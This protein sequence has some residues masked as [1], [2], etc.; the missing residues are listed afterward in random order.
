MYVK[1]KLELTWV[2]KND[3]LKIE[4]RILLVDKEKSYG[5]KNSGNMLIHGDNLLGLRALE[6]DYTN[7]IKCVYIDPPY[8]TGNAFEH[9]DDNLEHSIWLNL[10]NER[11]KI[12]Y[13]LLKNDGG[14]LI[15]Q[16]DVQEI[17]YCKILLDEI[18]G[19]NQFVA[20]ITYE[21]SGVGGLGQSGAIINTGEYILIYQKGARRVNEVKSYMPIELKQMKRYNKMIIDFGTKELVREFSSKSNG[22]TVK[23]FK[24]NNFKIDTFSFKDKKDE[25]L[26]RKEYG[27]CYD[28]LFRSFL[29]QKENAFQ[30]DIIKD[31]DKSCLY[32]VEYIPSRGKYEGQLTNLYYINKELIGWLKDTAYL[33]NGEVVKESKLTNIWSN[34][35]IP[36]ADLPNE[37]HVTFPRNKKP[38][39]LIKR[40]LDMFT[41]ENDLVLDSFL[42]SGTTAAVAHK[43]KRRWIGIEMGNHIYTH[44]IPRLKRIIDGEDKTGITKTMNWTGGGGYDFYELSPS[45]I[46]KDKFEESIINRKYD[47]NMLSEAIALQEGYDYNPSK[48]FFWKQAK[49]NENSFLYVTLDFIDQVLLEKIYNQMAE[50]EYLIVYCTNYDKKIENKFKR[51]KIKKIPESLLL[52]CE[53]GIENYNLNIKEEFVGEEYEEC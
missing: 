48:K 44:C 45:L 5:E 47:L 38:E 39:Q 17:H 53:Y 35:E 19:R 13:K 20:Q 28:K 16:L 46:E 14:T 18:F 30:H 21:R 37:G 31:M 41:K 3:N 34:A 15:V 49:G 32:S 50:N 8:N 10:M 33:E 12:L 29:I 24:H 25:L 22:E 11:L 27:E 26:F 1:N 2:G 9:Y 4:P 7:R 36:K 6:K 40:L 42:G 51:I 43:M 23:V 52:E